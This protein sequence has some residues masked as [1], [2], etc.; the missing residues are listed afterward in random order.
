M[1]I[2]GARD[3][4]KGANAAKNGNRSLAESYF[5]NARS[6]FNNYLGAGF[7]YSSNA[8]KVSN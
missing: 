7:N 4:K 1:A 5:S 2:A 8:C 6:L 3:L